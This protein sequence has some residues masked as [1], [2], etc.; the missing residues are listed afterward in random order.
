[1]M[2]IMKRQELSLEEKKLSRQNI[3]IFRYTFPDH[4][5]IGPLT[6]VRLI[7]HWLLRLKIFLIYCSRTG[8]PVW[9]MVT[10]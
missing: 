2:V 10:A 6:P 8:I 9:N 5:N 3:L 7:R 1:M 4:G